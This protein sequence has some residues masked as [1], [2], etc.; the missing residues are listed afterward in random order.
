MVLG[1][2]EHA[3]QGL[4]TQT[5]ITVSM[6]EGRFVGHTM[7]HT[8]LPG[9]FACQ[10]ALMAKKQNT[11]IQRWNSAAQAAIFPPTL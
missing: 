9:D 4:A 3:K 11:Q 6:S 10:P 5:S 1:S 8:I 7:A 2:T